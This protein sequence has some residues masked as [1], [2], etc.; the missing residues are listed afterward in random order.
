MTS[1]LYISFECFSKELD[2]SDLYSIFE[3]YY[4]NS[5]KFILIKNNQDFLL[6]KRIKSK[7]KIEWYGPGFY[8]ELES[9]VNNDEIFILFKRFY[10]G[11]DNWN[12]NTKW[13]KSRQYLEYKIGNKLWLFSVFSFLIFGSFVGILK[14]LNFPDSFLL[15]LYLYTIFSV[16]CISHAISIF[17]MGKFYYFGSIFFKEYSILYW[18]YIL[19]WLFLGIIPLVALGL[20]YLLK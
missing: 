13:V 9:N 12:E 5:L 17:L 8:N 15:G 4:D 14:I 3:D 18:L 19:L 7:D 16:V 2:Q 11:Y 10:Y 20:T 1:L 6:I